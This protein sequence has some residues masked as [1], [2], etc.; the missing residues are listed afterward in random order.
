M[1]RY[2]GVITCKW[3]HGVGSVP[4]HLRRTN[5]HHYAAP[6][7][8]DSAVG[9]LTGRWRELCSQTL[10]LRM[11]PAAAAGSLGQRTSCVAVVVVLA[12]QWRTGQ[13]ES[14]FVSVMCCCCK[15]SIWHTDGLYNR[16]YTVYEKAKYLFLSLAIRYYKKYT[17]NTQFS[18]SVCYY[19][20]VFL[21]IN[22]LFKIIISCRFVYFLHLIFIRKHYS[23]YNVHTVYTVYSYYVGTVSNMSCK[24]RVI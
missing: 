5:K 14:L 21:L 6:T 13:W 9:G 10:A 22:T 1:Q 12:P 24:I 4:P 18:Y 3:G 2:F 17:Q 23:M 20:L 8:A 16:L 15:L 7:P 19:N 11:K